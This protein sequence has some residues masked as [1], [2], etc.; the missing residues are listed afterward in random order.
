MI[1]QK[2]N[3]LPWVYCPANIWNNNNIPNAPRK[4]HVICI[5]KCPRARNINNGQ[6]KI[7]KPKTVATK[8]NIADLALHLKIKSIIHF[9]FCLLELIFV[10]RSAVGKES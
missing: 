1:I 8:L 2:R 3:K 4:C 6:A 10:L 9:L 7:S 5:F